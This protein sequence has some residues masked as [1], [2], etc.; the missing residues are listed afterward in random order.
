MAVNRPFVI[1]R[2]WPGEIRVNEMNGFIGEWV[3]FKLPLDSGAEA[4]LRIPLDDAFEEGLVTAADN[5][6]YPEDEENDG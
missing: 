4:E 5:L 6:Y 2:G 1:Q 3:V